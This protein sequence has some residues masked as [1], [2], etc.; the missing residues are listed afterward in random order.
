MSAPAFS[1][2]GPITLDQAIDGLAAR[3][4][5]VT[6]AEPV[7]LAAALG[8]VLAEDV[9]S[10]IDVPPH[11]NAAMD[12]IAVFFADLAPAGETRLPMTARVAAGHPLDR[13]ARRGEAVRI[14]TGAPMPEGPDT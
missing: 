8:R 6:E 3:L 13:P 1:D 14:F 12:G 9:V 2:L 4:T 11:D 5:P 10:A 7:A